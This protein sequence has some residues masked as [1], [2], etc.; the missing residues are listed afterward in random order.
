MGV[1]GL[2]LG[3]WGQGWG[4]GSYSER[5]CGHEL[6][7]HAEVRLLDHSPYEVDHVTVAHLVRVRLRVLG[8][9]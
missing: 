4:E 3:A 1:E 5:A 6:H 7:D 2:G 8:L 9:G